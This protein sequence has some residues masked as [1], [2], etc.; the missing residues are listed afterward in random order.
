M[1]NTIKIDLTKLK[2][3]WL[4]IVSVILYYAKMK[5]EE[6]KLDPKFKGPF[7][8]AE[9]LEADRYILKTLDSKQ[10]YK[11]SHDIL[12]KMPGSCIPTE[13]DVCSDGTNSDRDDMST[14][15]SEDR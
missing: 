10:S 15:I 9:I 11:S 12:R 5:K 4:D 8:I 1:L 6:T 14:P 3:K 7:V 13:L 2:L